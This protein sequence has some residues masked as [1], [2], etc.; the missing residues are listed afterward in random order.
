MTEHMKDLDFMKNFSTFDEN[1][2]TDFDEVNRY[3][4]RCHTD[5]IGYK[6]RFGMDHHHNDFMNF[7][8]KLEGVQKLVESG[9]TDGVASQVG[10]DKLSKGT[11]DC[12]VINTDMI[13]L[14]DKLRAYAGPIKTLLNAIPAMCDKN[15]ELDLDLS[16][17]IKEFVDWKGEEYV[18]EEEEVVE[19]FIDTSFTPFEF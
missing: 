5:L 8:R 13:K 9:D 1:V 15:V 19:E 11:V 16:M 7:M 3:V 10:F 14:Q 6:N 12:L 17:V 18:V 2:K 4:R